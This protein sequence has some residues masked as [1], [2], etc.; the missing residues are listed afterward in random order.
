MTS[1]FPTTAGIQ[2]ALREVVERPDTL[3]EQ[4]TAE[5]W[6]YRALA[7]YEKHRQTRDPAWRDRAKGYA[8]EALEH[9]ALARDGGKS[10][11]VIEKAL[12]SAAGRLVDTKRGHRRYGGK[13]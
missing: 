7:C 10:L 3:I 13:R 9:A 12:E 11:R 4:T 1:R 6:A 8:D 2:K 5:T